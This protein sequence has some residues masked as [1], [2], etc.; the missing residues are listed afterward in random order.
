M[1][2]VTP[3]SI[4]DVL[5]LEP[6]RFGDERGFFAETYRASVLAEHGFDRPFVQDNQAHTQARG[7]VRG[8][9]LQTGADAQ[10]KLVRVIRGAVFDVA[11]DIRVGSPWYGKAVTVE[12]SAQNLRQL[13]IPEGFAHGYMTLTE[14]AEAL[15]KV[16]AYYAPK[17]E[18]GL[19]WSDPALGIDWP[20]AAAEAIVNARD[21][22]WPT[23]A[24]LNSPFVYEAGR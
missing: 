5:L 10:A 6:D 21:Q 2:R 9:H 16:S 7:T 3:L 14:D 12:L 1:I 22:A 17:S 4:P 8:L 11:V 23:L 24:K 13:F 19:L 20:A 18:I 15:Y